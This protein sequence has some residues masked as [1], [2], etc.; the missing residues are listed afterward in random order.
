MSEATISHLQGRLSCGDPLGEWLGHLAIVNLLSLPDELSP[1]KHLLALNVYESYLLRSTFEER[2]HLLS[3]VRS[4][5]EHQ[6]SSG[7]MSVKL[8]EG[9][10]R[11]PPAPFGPPR[12]KEEHHKWKPEFEKIREDET[13]KCGRIE[14]WHDRLSR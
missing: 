13:N 12:V 2:D 7:G 8:L 1:E 9:V 5:K 11:I 4:C 6:A 10:E 3:Q 14:K